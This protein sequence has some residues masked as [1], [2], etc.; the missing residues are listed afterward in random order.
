M[1]LA[2]YR[3]FLLAAAGFIALYAKEILGLDL[4]N[5]MMDKIVDGLIAMLS[6]G[7]VFFV[8]NKVTAS[9]ARESMKSAL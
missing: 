6:L 8:R 2:K 4:E 3:K 5:G 1:D 7:S 9:E